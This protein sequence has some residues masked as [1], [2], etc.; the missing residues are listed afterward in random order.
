MLARLLDFPTSRHVT[1]ACAMTPGI[2]TPARLPAK[3]EGANGAHS[4]QGHHAA[5]LATS[6]HANMHQ[7]R[8]H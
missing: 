1:P 3:L 8:V 2:L 7:A 5:K 6:K 4:C